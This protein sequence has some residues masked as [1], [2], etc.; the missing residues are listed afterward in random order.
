MNPGTST[1]ETSGMLKASQ[2]RTNRPALNEASLSSTPASTAGWLATNPTVWPP[3]RPK[4][5]MMLRA[6]PA[7]TSMN[8]APSRIERMSTF[9]S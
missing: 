3:R 4:P 6:N 9:M 8:S 1:S 5:Q 7:C 2:K